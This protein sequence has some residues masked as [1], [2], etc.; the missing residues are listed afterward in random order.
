MYLLTIS[1]DLSIYRFF[2]IEVMYLSILFFK[3]LINLSAKVDFPS[4]CVEYN[5]TS[6]LNYDFTDLL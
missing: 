1:S 6:F 2:D 3:V 4:L 5:S